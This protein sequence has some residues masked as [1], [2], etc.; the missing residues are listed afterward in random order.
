MIPPLDSTTGHL[1][2]GR[3]RCSL[4]EIEACFVEDLQFATSITR[5]SRFDGLKNYIAAWNFI[6]K[7]V[8]DPDVLMALWIGGSF[9][10]SMLDPDD[11]DVSPQVN[12]LKLAALS[13]KPGTKALKTLFG[14]RPTVV[15]EYGVEPFPITWYPV[16]SPFAGTCSILEADYYQT[17]GALDD[18][19]QRVRPDGPKV[20]PRLDDAPSRR[21]YL[22]V[23]L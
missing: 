18:F 20:A 1:P 6:Q 15:K 19:W 14:H 2:L 23:I 17:R 4:E 11:V 10:S 8:G 9:T 21:G 16:A 3:Y 5:R 22:E 12:G 13:G 7:K